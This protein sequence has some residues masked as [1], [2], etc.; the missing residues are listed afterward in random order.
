MIKINSL[1]Q[2]ESNVIKML[3]VVEIAKRVVDETFVSGIK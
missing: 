2:V 3:N 1:I